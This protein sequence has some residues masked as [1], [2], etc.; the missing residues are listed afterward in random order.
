MY[1]KSAVSILKLTVHRHGIIEKNASTTHLQAGGKPSTWF[2]PG[3][4]QSL[5]PEVFD[6]TEMNLQNIDIEK[7]EQEH[8]NNDRSVPK[9]AEDIRNTPQ[10]CIQRL[11]L[12]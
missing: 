3:N 4:L 9:D 7:G 12:D 10:E 2:P 6:F 1:F 5:C 8:A 11:R